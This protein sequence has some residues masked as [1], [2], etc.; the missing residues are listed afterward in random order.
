MQTKSNFTTN[1]EY[2][3]GGKER[4]DLN[5]YKDLAFLKTF[6]QWQLVTWLLV[7]MERIFCHGLPLTHLISK[8]VGNCPCTRQLKL[9]S[10]KRNFQVS[11]E[12]L[13]LTTFRK[14]GPWSSIL[15]PC[16]GLYDKE[17]KMFKIWLMFYFQPSYS[18]KKKL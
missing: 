15:F 2:N 11:M 17:N 6:N 8:F 9:C 18:L 13:K 14:S 1:V 16:W 12:S 3:A 5:H 10:L 7:P 4:L